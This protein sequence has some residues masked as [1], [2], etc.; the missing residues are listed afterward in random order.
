MKGDKRFFERVR[1]SL[2]F[3]IFIFFSA[4]II[5]ISSGFIFFSAYHEL[6]AANEDLIKSG[7]TLSSFLAYS[8]RTSVFAEN[9]AMLSDAVQGIMNQK[10]VLAVAIYNADNKL[11]FSKIKGPLKK[12]QKLENEGAG[13][14]AIP[15][16]KKVL[17]TDGKD[18]VEFLSPVILESYL[19]RDEALYFDDIPS[20]GKEN[21]IGYVKVMLD[22][23]ILRKEIRTIVFKSIGMAILFLFLGAFVIYVTLKK[24]LRPLIKLTNAVNLFGKGEFIEKVTVESSDEI[25]KLAMAFNSMTDDLKGRDAENR[26]LE[27]QLRHSQKMETVGTLTGG[28]AHDFNNILTTIMN[29]GNLLK[30]KMGKD[31]PLRT[32]VSQILVASERAANLTNGLLSF[33]RK[34]IIKPRPVRLNDIVIKVEKLLYLIIGENIELNTM[35]AGEDLEDLTVIADSGQIEQVLIN[36]C[37][38]ARDAMPEGGILTI[39]TELAELDSEFRKTHGYGKPGLYAVV[40]VADTGT[41]MDE[42]TRERIFEPF[43]TTKDVGKGTGLGLSIAYGIIRQH[44]GYINCDSE[45]GKG[46]TFKAYLPLAESVCGKTESSA[47]IVLLHG[48]ETVLV[49]ED[50]SDVREVT[51]DILEEFG[52]KVIEATDGEDAVNKFIENKDRIGFLLFDVKMPKKNGKEAYDEIKKIRP[53][54]KALFLSGYA[55]DIINKERLHEDGI[56]IMTKPVPPTELLRKMRELLDR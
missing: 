29:C 21:V 4:F 27:E 7:E 1:N 28:I 44:N 56:N 45:T 19:H 12:G 46:T 25:G 47:G 24:V 50:D 5:I 38:N 11:L 26:L 16:D 20:A 32:Y 39:K 15:G 22:K 31:E 48:S 8:T 51:R 6:R 2:S 42:K 40:S 34:Q 10:N 53:D 54:I 37:T 14:A 33:S 43:F 23:T 35:L 13:L 41:G 52:Y 36:L 17:I 55:E 49:A 9:R 30:M 18:T 3:K